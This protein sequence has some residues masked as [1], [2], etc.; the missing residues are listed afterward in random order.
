MSLFET[1]IWILFLHAIAYLL[2][3][4]TFARESKFRYSQK[5]WRKKQ[6]FA[7]LQPIPLL[8]LILLL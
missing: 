1:V 4:W 3:H 7:H 6:W 5:G 2:A 8:V